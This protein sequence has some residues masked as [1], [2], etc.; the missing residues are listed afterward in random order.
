MLQAMVNISLNFGNNCAKKQ[1][2]HMDNMVT[3]H[4]EKYLLLF[5]KKGHGVNAAVNQSYEITLGLFTFWRMTVGNNQMKK[6]LSQI[7]K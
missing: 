1:R 4:L 3:S 7:L 6:Q 2:F 5:A